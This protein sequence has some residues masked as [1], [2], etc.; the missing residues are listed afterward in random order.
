[1]GETERA[2]AEAE[3]LKEGDF[4]EF[5][6]LMKESGDSS[7]KLLQNVYVGGASG[8]TGVNDSRPGA[9]P[10]AVA[11]AVSELV[12]GEDGVCRVHGGGFAGTIQAF[13]KTE[14]VGRYKAAM[15]KLFGDGACMVMSF[16][17]ES[18]EA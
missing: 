10:I 17:C 18:E 3:A 6:R 5:L 16:A 14:A 13:V 7:Y 1:M 9:Q 4:G 2:K 12:L 15:D 8:C 11:L